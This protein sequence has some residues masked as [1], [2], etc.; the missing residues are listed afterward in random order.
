MA[1]P[2]GTEASVPLTRLYVPPGD[3]VD[4]IA[5]TGKRGGRKTYAERN[6]ALVEAAKAIKGRG[7][8]VSLREVAAAP[9]E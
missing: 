6:P 7:A 1:M 2:G 8:R 9:T 5:A 4:F 3:F